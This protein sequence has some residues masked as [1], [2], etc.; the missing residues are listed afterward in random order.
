MCQAVSDPRASDRGVLVAAL[1][2]RAGRLRAMTPWMRTVTG[3]LALGVALFGCGARSSLPQPGLD[4]DDGGQGGDD[5]PSSG[6][7][8]SSGDGGGG[9]DGTG[10]EGTGGEAPFVEQCDDLDLLFVYVVTSETDLYKFDPSTNEFTR[11]GALQCPAE[12]GT[13]PFSMAVS[14]S[15]RAYSVFTSGEL[16]RINVKDASCRATDWQPTFGDF[17]VFGMGYAIDDD[18]QG[19]SLFVAD[20]DFASDVSAGLAHLDTSTFELEYI[21]PF[22][23][24]PG[25]AIELTSADDGQLYG[26]FENNGQTGGTLVRIDKHTAEILEETPL[27]PPTTTDAGALAFAYWNGDFYIFTGRDSFSTVT[28]YRPSTGEVA[29]VATLDREIVGAGVTT[30]DPDEAAAD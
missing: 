6:S 2:L 12:P 8:A 21:N 4:G 15:G 13:S 22:S 7:G 10:G 17:S 16:F 14:R 27:P 19:E 20:I 5:R 23:S 30:C 24:N 11:I 9:R 28:R 3:A 26:Y 29:D 18:G 25:S 1:G